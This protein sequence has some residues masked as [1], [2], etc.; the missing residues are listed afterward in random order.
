MQDLNSEHIP[1]DRLSDVVMNESAL[2]ISEIEHLKTC[3]ECLEL[4][5]LAV[6][7]R[8]QDRKRIQ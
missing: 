4:I 1:E 7:K 6:R 3:S 2:T 8:I 5:R